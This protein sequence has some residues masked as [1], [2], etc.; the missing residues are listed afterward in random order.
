MAHVKWSEGI[1][2]LLETCSQYSGMWPTVSFR[3]LGQPLDEPNKL[4]AAVVHFQ[5][6]TD[7][8]HESVRITMSDPCVIEGTVSIVNYVALLESWRQGSSGDLVGWT[9]E[10]PQIQNVDWEPNIPSSWLWNSALEDVTG[11]DGPYICCRLSG[12]G[13]DSLHDVDSAVVDSAR[14]LQIS[15][16]EWME[17]YV[18]IT[19]SPV[20]EPFLYVLLPIAVGLQGQY[21]PIE[22]RCSAT[23]TYRSPYQIGDFWIRLGT[24]RWESG[25]PEHHFQKE[26]D[27]EHEWKQ[28]RFTYDATHLATGADTLNIWVGAGDDN[29]RFMWSTR[30]SLKS[31]QS[32]DDIRRR[33]LARWYG[34]VNQSI[35]THILPGREG[36][37]NRSDRTQDRF[38]VA[39]SN[40]CGALGY[41]VLF[42]GRALST[43]G[44]DFVAFDATRSRAY[45]FSVT[46]SNNVNEKLRTLKL[47]LHD[48]GDASTGYMLCPI[49][50]CQVARE[51]FLPEDL[52][53]AQECSISVLGQ[54]DLEPL[55]VE[56]V[57]LE[58]FEEKLLG[59]LE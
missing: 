40:V 26:E 32:A 42:G 3:I 46:L 4:L 43:S 25:L 55:T 12:R 51:C 8:L 48:I 54:E 36:R 16:D 41:A 57:D 49:V 22:D 14:A 29:S 33:F 20:V 35:A 37:K 27:K 7:A 17:E 2:S 15:R 21:D 13:R 10:P 56:P 50:V 5:A 6:I 9:V 38:E 24:G 1:Q 18:G 30:V 23:L 11:I 39:L 58:R 44:A 31:T 59:L 47:F 52:R 34:L 19:I 53:N 28:A 45:V